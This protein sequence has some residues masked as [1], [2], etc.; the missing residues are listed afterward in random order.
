[1]EQTITIKVA[2]AAVLQILRNFAALKLVEFPNEAANEAQGIQSLPL[3]K[4]KLLT[5]EEQI[6]YLNEIY[7]DVDTSVDPA[8]Y[9]AQMEVLNRDSVEW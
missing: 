9:N 2:N 7:K 5:E 6:A 4:F 8:L 3:E 1:M